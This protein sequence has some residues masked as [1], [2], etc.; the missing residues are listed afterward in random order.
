MK[1]RQYLLD[2]IDAAVR[3]GEAILEVYR[4]DFDV[5]TKD[6]NSPLT[7]ADRKAHEIIKAALKK[8]DLPS[9]S[10]EGRSI[11]YKTRSAW[12]TMWIV[13]PLDGTKEFVKRNDEFTVN[14]A[15]VKG[16]RPVMGVIYSPV[17]DWLY[18]AST[19]IGAYKIIDVHQ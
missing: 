3:A 2:A 6:D 1:Y 9:I 13:D 11:D 8:H 15:L 19:Q 12:R 7:L 10:E 17:L 5:E 18:F 14:I 16:Q 4:T